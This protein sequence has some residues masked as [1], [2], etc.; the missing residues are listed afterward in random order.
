[1]I[2]RSSVVTLSGKRMNSKEGNCFTQMMWQ[3]FLEII[4]G[5][6]DATEVFL[7]N[8]R[9]KETAEEKER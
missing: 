5:V 3:Q 9:E 7:I 2:C 6:S 8:I 4:R 1:M